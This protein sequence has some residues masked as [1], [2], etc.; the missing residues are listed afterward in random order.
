MG[1]RKANAPGLIDDE[2][3]QWQALQHRDRNVEFR[4]GQQARIMLGPD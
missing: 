3:R 1:I 4:S 2:N